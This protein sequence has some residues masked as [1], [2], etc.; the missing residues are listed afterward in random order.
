MLRKHCGV[1]YYDD[2]D[3]Y[4]DGLTLTDLNHKLKYYSIGHR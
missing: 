4:V 2:G 3:D 1:D